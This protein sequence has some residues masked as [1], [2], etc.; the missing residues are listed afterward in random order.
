MSL[1]FMSREKRDEAWV[2]SGKRGRRGTVTNQQ[3]HPMYVEDFE[4][5]E[6]TQTGLGNT[7]YKT[8]F[9]KL[10]TLDN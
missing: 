1:L 8:F 5:P 9:S 10:Y 7:V 3:L 2:A 4:G 6:K